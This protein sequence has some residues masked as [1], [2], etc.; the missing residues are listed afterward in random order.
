MKKVISIIG[1][2]WGALLLTGCNTKDASAYLANPYT[3]A[4]SIVAE[5]YNKAS[6][7]YVNSVAA[8][9]KDPIANG[10][11]HKMGDATQ[12]YYDQL[13]AIDISYC[14]D[15]FRLA[16]VKYYQAVYAWKT[17]IKSITGWNGFIK[18]FVSP[19]SIIQL[20]SNTD[21]AV[22]PM[23]EAGNELTL[24]CTKYHIAIK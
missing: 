16:F 2:F 14:P 11:S 22:V 6:I 19:G 15:D 24:V 8:L 13:V 3:K 5:Q 20:Q 21:K 1:V 17:Y 7:E 4:I 9:Q 12:A 18:G 10:L 23:I